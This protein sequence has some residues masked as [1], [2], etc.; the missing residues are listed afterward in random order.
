[1]TSLTI[2]DVQ[3]YQDDG[4]LFPIRA[5]G[6]AETTRFRNAFEELS[7]RVEERKSYAPSTHLFFSWAYE[8]V[9]HP[10]VVG[11][12][13]SL[14]GPD[15]LIDSSVVLCK[16]PGDRA[17]APWH[18]DGTYSGWHTT[19]SVSAWIALSESTRENG[20]MRV[21][22][23]SHHGGRYPHKMVSNE[24]ILFRRKSDE[25][26]VVVDESL[27]RDVVLR[28]GEF[29]LHHS[30]IVHGSEA[31]RSAGCR[32]GFVVRYVTPAFQARKSSTPLVRACGNTDCGGL[33]IFHGT[34]TSQVDESYQSWSNFT[35]ALF[36]AVEDA[37]EKNK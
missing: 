5:L 17:F 7:L 26:E 20:C 9:T 11:P 25:V 8:L 22:P 2:G 29:S 4:V 13:I 19:P 23:G 6:D 35:R 32:I 14:L 30:S 1:M 31:N 24:N 10:G 37:R 21:I 33:P 16:Y 34:P 18:Q 27:A 28:P 36:E 3:R 12:V 15:I